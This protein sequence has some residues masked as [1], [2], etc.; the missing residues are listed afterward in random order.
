MSRLQSILRWSASLGI[1]AAIALG[2]AI[3]VVSLF[4]EVQSSQQTVSCLANI[5][6]INAD[7]LLLLYRVS[8]TNK[9]DPSETVLLDKMRSQLFA[10][11]TKIRQYSP[12]LVTPANLSLELSYERRIFRTADL[13]QRGAHA[14]ASRR[15]ATSLTTSF[16]LVQQ[17][18][19]ATARQQSVIAS[20]TSMVADLE[21]LTMM[22]FAA[23]MTTLL[24]R[25]FSR[26][27][28]LSELSAARER[29]RSQARFASL[30]ASSS[31][32]IVVVN[33]ELEILFVTPS[34]QRTLGWNPQVWIGRK[35]EEIVEPEDR[36][37]FMAEVG[38]CTKDNDSTITTR[39]LHEDGS[40]RTIELI[41]RNLISDPKVGAIVI[42]ARDVT[43]RH[44]LEMQLTRAALYDS[45][46]GLP[47][48]ALFNE[49]L[50]SAI[51]Q[52]AKNGSQTA[53]LFIDLDEFKV[54][55]DTLGHLS[56]DELLRC[57]AERLMKAVP[58]S[59]TV[60]RLGG[61][62][63]GVLLETA[64]HAK[65]AKAV[66]LRVI[67]EIKGEYQLSN[68]VAH[69]SAS[70]G[71]AYADAEIEVEE[72]LKRADIAMYSAKRQDHYHF[73]TYD[74]AMQQDILEKL[75][76]RAELQRAVENGQL[77]VVYQPV[78]DLE[79]GRIRGVEA[80]VRWNHPQRGVLSPTV[81]IPIAE[82]SGLIVEIGRFVQKT[83]CKQ[84]SL[85]NRIRG[86]KAM[87]MNVNL[88]VREL[89]E[90]SL[91]AQVRGVIED[92]G[93]DPSQ[94]TL[95]VTE[96]HVMAQVDLVSERLHQLRDLGI[97]LA[98]DDFGTGYSSL[99]Y[100]EHLPVDALKIDKSFTDHLLKEETPVT[101]KTILRLGQELNLKIVAEGIERSS[102]AE[103]LLAL[104]CMYGQ[105]YHFARPLEA[106]AIDE[107][108][109]HDE[110][111]HPTRSLQETRFTRIPLWPSHFT[112]EGPI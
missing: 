53:I 6:R 98:I 95:E 24:F 32:V 4:D 69:V 55:N 105:G 49:R 29:E 15:L 60:S 79:E 87:T 44:E 31:D 93:I 23:L 74:D 78:V 65:D 39:W 66:A 108:L 61:D 86:D 13:F 100:L 7:Q 27:K 1:A 9:L 20:E 38:S 94:L 22:A 54:V 16:Q 50:A 48:R 52:N 46:T 43:E 99:S 30:V 26:A 67:E 19:Q 112:K 64:E 21:T 34:W 73:A 45:L 92:S 81:F 37:L 11:V 80:L 58:E 106:E 3:S 10:E 28:L 8:E 40:Y 63:F 109:R 18:T 57:V 97:K 47:N 110:N 90:P 68:G 107:M 88:S 91:V 14:A 76:L 75:T 104:G 96:T 17:K 35:I 41:A 83:A 5:S 62:E 25:K 59:E 84:L 102:Q 56:G 101:L 2:M 85:W 51:R 71:H 70:V 36:L 33:P 103:S 42:N 89:L 82:D 77:Y 111:G 72:L 12:S